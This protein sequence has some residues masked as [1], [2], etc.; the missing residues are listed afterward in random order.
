MSVPRTHNT[1]QQV[2]I[3]TVHGSDVQERSERK[4]NQ[5]GEAVWCNSKELR[6]WNPAARVQISA[7]PLW[8]Y[9]IL[10]S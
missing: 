5:H 7:L 10:V 1:V 8:G 4:S 2:N 9:V 6:L 3:R